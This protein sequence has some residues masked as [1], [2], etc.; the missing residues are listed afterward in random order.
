MD[1][2]VRSNVS[3]WQARDIT[4]QSKN[5]YAGTR[6]VSDGYNPLKKTINSSGLFFY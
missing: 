6:I 5:W 1:L 2:K 4:K 3:F